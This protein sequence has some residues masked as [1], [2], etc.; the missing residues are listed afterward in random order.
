MKHSPSWEANRSSDSQEIPHNL[1]KAEV[2]CR[3]HQSPPSACPYPEPDQS[4]THHPF[5]LFE[6][7]L[8][9]STPGCS[10]W[11]FWR[12]NVYSFVLMGVHHSSSWRH[13]LA[14][15]APRALKS[16][17]AMTTQH[18]TTT[19]RYHVNRSLYSVRVNLYVFFP[20]RF[21][22]KTWCAFLFSPYMLRAPVFS[23]IFQSGIEIMRLFIVQFFTPPYPH[24]SPPQR[25]ILEHCQPQ[26]LPEC[27]RLGFTP[28]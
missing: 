19:M 23:Y 20:S 28:I 4:N 9:R 21:P 11:G 6:D 2:R 1:W 12:D 17:V 27:E 14:R 5:L 7:P 22:I 3:I 26:F 8:I 24:L 25:P 16:G 10:A 15:P 18:Y 13:I